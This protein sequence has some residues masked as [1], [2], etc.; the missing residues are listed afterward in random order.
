[1]NA[2]PQSIQSGQSATLTWQSQNATQILINGSPHAGSEGSVAVT[3][4]KTMTY[5]VEAKGPGGTATAAVTVNVQPAS[6]ATTTPPPPTNQ[7]N[8]ENSAIQAALDR[9][10]SAYGT[11]L[12]SEV[13]KAW[14]GMDKQQ[15]N[16]LKAVL[17]SKDMRAI[18]VKFDACSSP[19]VTGNT[20]S[21]TCTERM[22]YTGGGQRKE[23]PATKVG[24]S[25]KKAGDGWQVWSKYPPK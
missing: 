15:E 1:V 12:I 23:L 3:P 24:I 19:V 5:T 21:M 4:D 20:A 16:G 7:G 11:T 2:S 25:L 13:K 9:L 14:P 6:V 22:S 8:S 10:S 18:A 17:S